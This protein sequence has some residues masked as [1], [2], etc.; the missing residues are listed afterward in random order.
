MSTRTIRATIKDMMPQFTASE[1]KIANVILADYP[2][3][4]LEGIREVAARTGVSAP[5]IT[6]FVAKIGAAGFGDFQRRII[7]EM[8]EGE[9]S[10]L[11]LKGRQVEV[12]ESNFLA[13]YSQRVTQVLNEM[14]ETVPQAQLDAVCELLAD[15][16]R[17]IFLIGGR[18]TDSIATFLSIHLR[19]L[20]HH[21]FHI[22]RDPELQPEYIL[23]M[24]KRD[25]VVIFDFRRYQHNLETLA[26]II[27]QERHASII[28]I[29]DKWISPVAHHSSQIIALPIDA[30]TAWDT[31]IAAI[32]FVEALVVK[33]SGVNWD[34]AQDRI[35]SWD[36]IRFRQE[37][38]G[39]TD[40]TK[41]NDE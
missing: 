19:Q 5:S 7:G 28:L 22:S 14:S 32:A 33:V 38:L 31:V 37:A 21:V 27:R 2:F 8:K 17:S 18:V 13:A 20:R 36:R 30:G 4:A 35:K 11:D 29:T 6:R 16:T 12:E 15:P 25:V 10:P 40:Q 24:R 41:G 26:A 1:R 3:T 23:R 34:A 39:D 9:Q